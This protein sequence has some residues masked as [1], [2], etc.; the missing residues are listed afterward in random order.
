MGAYDRLPARRADAVELLSARDAVP[1]LAAASLAA[2]IGGCGA[3]VRAERASASVASASVAGTWTQPARLGDCP[4]SGPARAAFPRDSPSHAT[5]AGAIVWSAASSCAGGAGTLVSRLDARDDPTAPFYARSPAGGRLALRGPL[6]IA[7]APNGQ[8][9]IAGSASS[10][11]RADGALVQGGASGPF[12]PLGA[13]A[14][15]ASLG[16]LATG[17]LGDLAAVSPTTTGGAGHGAGGVRV[18][19]ER[20]FADALS[21]PRVI[22]PRAGAVQ[23]PTVSVDYRTDA[24]AVWRQAGSLYARHLPA[25]GRGEPTQRLADVDLAPHVVSLLSDDNRGIVAWA[26]E[27]AGT[28]SVYLDLSGANVRFGR[29]RLLERFVDPAGLPDPIASPRLVRLSTESVMLAWSGAQDGH[30]VVRTAAIDFN[31]IGPAR[32]V[33]DPRGEALLS[34]L[35]P[36]PHGDALALWTEPQPGADGR[37]SVALQSLAAA[38]GGDGHP[39]ETY[40]GEPETIAP[41]GPNGEATIA[42]DPASDRAVALWRG[43]GG[44]IEY[45]IRE[46]R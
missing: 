43:A 33:S 21:S 6:S 11:A 40:F 14:G 2:G 35:Q 8:I 22:G 29:P 36:G 42:V 37:P 3:E 45:A 30:W 9:A 28:T 32:T 25:S 4:A 17:Y 41:P 10:P 7:P 12:T 34:D 5:G 31:G 18:D 44:A 38:R 19:V 15:T 27:R 23:T 16:T 20:Y 1:L 13:I 46:P 24:L 39:D 26:D